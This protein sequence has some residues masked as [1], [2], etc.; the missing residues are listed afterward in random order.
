MASKKKKRPVAKK[1]KKKLAPKKPQV[2]KAKK[3]EHDDDGD[4]AGKGPLTPV[5]DKANANIVPVSSYTQ[6]DGYWNLLRNVYRPVVVQVESRSSTI[7]EF[8]ILSPDDGQPYDN[9]G[10]P[11]LFEADLDDG[12]ITYPYFPSTAQLVTLPGSNIV[13]YLLLS[14]DW[15]DNELGGDVDD[16][17]GAKTPDVASL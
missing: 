11:V 13:G 2:K 12:D 17:A 10:G 7:I 5:N 14:C 4:C 6:L 3:K 1:H 15:L 9:G 8:Y 16:Y